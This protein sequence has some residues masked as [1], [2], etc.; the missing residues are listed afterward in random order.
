MPFYPLERLINLHDGYRRHVKVDQ[1]DIVLAQEDGQL[2]IFQS[3]CPHRGQPLEK[4]S[5]EDGR[6]VCPLHQYAFDLRTGYQQDQLCA[7]LQVWTPIYE[8]N[9]VGI[10]LGER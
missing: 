8:G 3:R 6:L 5:I 4:A 7:A 9:Q 2:F 10:A 1:L